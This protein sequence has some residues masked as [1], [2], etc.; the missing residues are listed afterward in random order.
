MAR[1]FSIVGKSI[2]KIDGPELVTGQAQYSIDE[3]LPGMLPHA[4]AN[5]V[6]IDTSKAEALLGVRAALTYK[7]VLEISIDNNSRSGDQRVLDREVRYVG[8]EVAVLA[9]DTEEIAEEALKLIDVKYKVLPFVGI[10]DPEEALQPDAPIVQSWYSPESNLIGGE[11]Q[12]SEIGDIEQGFKESDRIYESVFTTFPQAVN[13]PGRACAV[14]WWQGDRLTIIDSNPS[15]RLYRNQIATWLQIPYNKI[16]YITKFCGVS[17]GGSNVYRY[18]GMAAYL[19]RK[20]NRPVKV[21]TDNRYGLCGSTRRRQRAKVYLKFGV[22]DDGTIM[23][24]GAK[25]I[26]DKGASAASGSLAG[27]LTVWG[28]Y[29]C[30]NRK[31][32]TWAVWTNT[33]PN[34]CHRAFGGEITYFALETFIDRIAND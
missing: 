14:A 7:D 20:I 21:I 28:L 34:G 17:M 27:Y 10:I 18:P 32:E 29:E 5:I 19:A 31:D 6:S 24:M 11:P 4:H 3:F 26:W 1:E 8:D 23:A 16:R 12:I 22:K 2:P 15:V 13:P 30:P 25:M 9:A 33:P